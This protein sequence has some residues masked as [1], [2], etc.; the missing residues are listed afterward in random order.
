MRWP[1]RVVPHYA[2]LPEDDVTWSGNV[3]V[4]G[5]ARTLTDCGEEGGRPDEVSKALAQGLVRGLFSAD[6]VATPTA[7]ISAWLERDG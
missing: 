6:D 4:T 3:P 1:E 7:R 2:D 5:A